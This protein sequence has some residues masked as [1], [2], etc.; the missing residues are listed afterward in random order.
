MGVLGSALEDEE[1]LADNG[2]LLVLCWTGGRRENQERR[3]LESCFS[4]QGTA[5]WPHNDNLALL[6]ASFVCG[7]LRRSLSLASISAQVGGGA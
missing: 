6:N 4:K 5:K 2:L 3:C 7:V 1:A